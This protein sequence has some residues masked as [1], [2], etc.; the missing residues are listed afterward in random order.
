MA[1]IVDI[2]QMYSE[3]EHESRLAKI[4]WKARQLETPITGECLY[5]AEPLLA[6]RRWCNAE[7]RDAW[8]KERGK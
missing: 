1:D 6:A 3:A 7:H 8:Q 2:A 5:C 4:R